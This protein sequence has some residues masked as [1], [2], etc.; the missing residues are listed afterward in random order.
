L[1]AIPQH[2]LGRHALLLFDSKG[3]ISAL[4]RWQTSGPVSHAGILL[5]NGDVLEAMQG[6]G[7]RVRPSDQVDWST[8]RAFDVPGCDWDKAVA[9]GMKQVG[10]GYDYLSILRIV[11]RF[12]SPP[13]DRYFCSEL[14][15]EVVEEGGVRLLERVAASKVEP[16]HLYTSP[17]PQEITS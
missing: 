8:V 15:F 10:K 11:T 13:N 6:A 9:F 4:I 5:P 16:V 14:G 7:V 2:L 17:I 12:R 3:I 1:S